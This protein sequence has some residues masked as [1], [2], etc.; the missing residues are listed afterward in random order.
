MDGALGDGILKENWHVKDGYI[1]LP[2]KPG[3]GF[4]IDEEALK[5]RYDGNFDIASWFH[6]DDGSVADW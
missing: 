4:E 5:T 3:L 6:D 2:Q 1:D